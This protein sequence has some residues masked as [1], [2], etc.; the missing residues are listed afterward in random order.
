V[1]RVVAAIGGYMT[2]TMGLML[3]DW[4][5]TLCGKMG[6]DRTKMLWGEANHPSH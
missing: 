3:I 1:A 2:L 6:E 4:I 5:Q